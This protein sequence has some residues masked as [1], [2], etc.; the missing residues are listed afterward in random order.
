MIKAS[1]YWCFI[2]I[3][4]FL[5]LDFYDF[6]NQTSILD[7]N[8]DSLKQK[9]NCMCPNVNP[10]AEALGHFRSK[11]NKWSCK[12]VWGNQ[13]LSIFMCA[14]SL[15]FLQSTEPRISKTNLRWKTTQ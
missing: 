1:N 14:S 2:F 5:Y 12:H 13:E 8:A 6:Q 15:N 4:L 10:I 9:L 3:I 11:V 7:W